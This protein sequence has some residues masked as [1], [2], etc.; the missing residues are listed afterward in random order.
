MKKLILILTVFFS[1]T[2]AQGQTNVYHSFSDSAIWRVDTWQHNPFQFWYYAYHHFQY[3]LKNDT[4]INTNIYKSIYRSFD[5]VTD[6]SAMPPMPPPGPYTQGYMGGLRDD[7]AANKVWFRF[8]NATNDS[9]LFDYNI[10]VGDSLKGFL[11]QYPG[12]INNLVVLSTDSVLINGLYRKR[13]NFNHD[14]NNNI[15][16]II[17]GIGSSS[18]LLEPFYT[19]AVDF[20]DRYIVCVNDDSNT[21]FVSTYN[22]TFGCNQIY[23]G[24]TKITFDNSFTCYPNPFST[25][26]TLKTNIFLKD[27]TLT[28]YNSYGQTVKQIKNISGQSITLYRDNI[29]SGLY[30]IRLTQGNKTF[31]TEKLIIID[32]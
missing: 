17:E 3:Y 1:L 26:T 28:L 22:S 24:L 9:L 27:A 8:P 12:A 29:Q 18:G 16:Y 5:Y 4:I 25:Q 13:W 11:S 2:V 7:P 30:F 31:A 6:A 20:T 32:N 21:I 15:Q 19:Y 10:N 23:E 14:I